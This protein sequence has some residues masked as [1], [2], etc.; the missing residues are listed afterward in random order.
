MYVTPFTW[1]NDAF[2]TISILERKPII[3]QFSIKWDNLGFNFLITPLRVLAVHQT[4]IVYE[5]Y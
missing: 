1:N 5:L 4:S 3:S 2:L